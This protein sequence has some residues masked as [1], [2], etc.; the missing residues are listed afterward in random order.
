MCGQLILHSVVIFTQNSLHVLGGV[1]S[2]YQLEN[3]YISELASCTASELT[4]TL[5]MML[6]TEEA[7]VT[8]IRATFTSLVTTV[9]TFDSSALESSL[10]VM[11]A[12]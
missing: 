5:E 4:I 12:S 9:T 7:K 6:T 3:T 10:F 2:H 8:L 11:S 1:N